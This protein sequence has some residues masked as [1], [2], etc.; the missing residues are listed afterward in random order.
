MGTILV[1]KILS[2]YLGA[3]SANIQLYIKSHISYLY[4]ITHLVHLSGNFCSWMMGE[5][6]FNFRRF[7][8]APICRGVAAK[9]TDPAVGFGMTRFLH[10]MQQQQRF[11]FN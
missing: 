11:D 8:F 1:V 9:R 10:A 6:N 4:I 2:Y 3:V 5:N 7:V